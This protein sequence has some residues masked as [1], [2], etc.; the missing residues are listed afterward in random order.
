MAQPYFLRLT[1]KQPLAEDD[2]E[3]AEYDAERGTLRC[4]VPKRNHAEHFTGLDML[5]QLLTKRP[6]ASAAVPLIEVMPGGGADCAEAADE[7]DET[8]SEW[9]WEQSLPDGAAVATELLHEVRYGFN[10][11]SSGFFRDLQQGAYEIVDLPN[12]NTTPAPQR[13]QLRVADEDA[14]FDPEHVVADIIDS[15]QIDE[16]LAYESPWPAAPPLRVADW[17]RNLPAR[18][19]LSL[20]PSVPSRPWQTAVAWTHAEQ[21]VLRS[22]PRKEFILEDELAT[23]LGLVDILF[24]FAYDQRTTMGEA[25]SESPWTICKLSSVLSWMDSFH[26]LRGTISSCIRRSLA[27]PLY[28]RWELSLAVLHDVSSVLAAGRQCVLRSLLGVK[29]ALDSSETKYFLSRLYIN[30]YCAWIQTVSESHVEARLGDLASE[31]QT[32]QR[33]GGECLRNAAGWHYQI[34]VALREALGDGSESEGSN[35]GT[36]ASSDSNESIH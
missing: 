32:M 9:E 3:R 21:D 11:S 28:R 18:G 23:W 35:S 20:A 27:F 4:F 1:F 16:L 14:C 31:L 22:L 33:D 30:D 12:P 8:G 10:N 19:S 26:S 6:L 17:R 25:N 5:T 24:A 2:R 34:T 29:A 36:S 13:T 15:D 7:W